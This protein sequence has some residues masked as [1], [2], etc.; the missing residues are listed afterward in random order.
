MRANIVEDLLTAARDAWRYRWHAAALAWGV[1]LIGWLAVYFVPDS[2]N[3]TARVFVD[4][5][6]MLNPL[7]NGLAADSLLEQQIAVMSRTLINRPNLERVLHITHMDET[8]KSAVERDEAIDRLATHIEFKSAGTENLYAVAY[9]DR[10]P[11]RAKLVVQSLLDMFVASSLGAGRKDMDLTRRFIDDE[12]RGYE[13]KLAAAENALKNFKRRNLGVMPSDKQ[14]YFSR[15]DQAN[16]QLRQAR[17]ELRE[18]QSAREAILRRMADEPADQR[19]IEVASNSDLR[20]GD[21]A[22]VPAESMNP[23][24]DSRIELARDNL[25][26]LRQKFTDAHPDVMAAQRALGNLEAQRERER[27]RA[28]ALRAQDDRR[29][30]ASPMAARSTVRRERNPVLEQLKVSLAD[31][32]AQIATLSAR[33]GEYSRRYAELRAQADQVPQVEADLTQLNRDYEVNRANYEKLLQRRESE[34]ISE[35]MASSSRGI[36][37]RIVEPPRVPLHPSGPNRL[38][39]ISLVFLMGVVGAIAL[40]IGLSR[41]WPSFQSERALR[42][43]TRRPVLGTVSLVHAAQ[44]QQAGWNTRMT[45]GMVVLGLFSCYA[46]LVGIITMVGI[47][48]A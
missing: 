6:T 25:D 23:A 10:D 30:V 44:R 4:T 40:A 7:M 38:L 28:A 8:L 13:S 43:L 1:C 41:V 20:T 48:A 18:A 15:L 36:D 32:E 5:R 9:R 37:F 26:Q 35:N 47:A 17:L 16:T 29:T 11:A 42:Q 2:Y 34:Q 31:Q 19:Q 3:A 24:L 45:F 33:V 14:D 46:A 22:P 39:L 12:I 21:P 27:S